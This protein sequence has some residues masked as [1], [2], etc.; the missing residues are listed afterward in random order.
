[1]FV[2]LKRKIVKIIW[3]FYFSAFFCVLGFAQ[4]ET[5]NWFFGNYAGLKFIPDGSVENILS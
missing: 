5:S 1:M 4:N 2:A 3:H